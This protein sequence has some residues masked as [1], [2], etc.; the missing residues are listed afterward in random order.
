MC[1]KSSPTSS[2]SIVTPL[3]LFIRIILNDQRN[4]PA[5]NLEHRMNFSKIMRNLKKNVTFHHFSS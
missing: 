5:C 4:I 1:D 3:L 2:G